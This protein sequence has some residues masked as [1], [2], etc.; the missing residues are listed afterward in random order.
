M[1]FV[2]Y[3]GYLIGFISALALLLIL[4]FYIRG[5]ME[6]QHRSGLISPEKMP[7]LP[8]VGVEV[9]EE[10]LST[11]KR[12]VHTLQCTECHGSDLQGKQRDYAFVPNVLASRAY[13]SKETM[14][15]AIKYGVR[16]DSSRMHPNMPSMQ[17]F[18]HL[19]KRDLTAIINYIYSLPALESDENKE[20]G[21]GRPEPDFGTKLRIGYTHLM[22]PDLK[23][24][25]LAGDTGVASK[26][27]NKEDGP[28]SYGNYLTQIHCA[29]CHSPNLG[30]DPGY[31]QT[32]DVSIGGAYSLDQLKALLKEGIGLGNREL[33]YM[34]TVS[35]E[36][37]SYLTD[38]EIAAIHDYLK[39]R[40]NRQAET[41]LDN[42][43]SGE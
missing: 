11:G 21:F 4:V 3:F 9:T 27:A 35:K 10:L 42:K 36:N 16:F 30:G 26:A 18:Y 39:H 17:S 33:G 31:W 13:Y 12:R 32:P 7:P 2:K 6:W 41:G 29:R 37:L 38:E 14:A 20:S 8:E 1:K 22:V 19:N 15:L 34:T 25:L 24:P 5:E 28:I 43:N 23:R 40:M